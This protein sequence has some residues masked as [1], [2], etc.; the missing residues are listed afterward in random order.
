VQAGTVSVCIPTYRRNERLRALLEDLRLQQRPPEQIVV[1]D[2]DASGSARPVIEEVRRSGIGCALDY[3]IQ[4]EPNIAL[5]RNRTVALATGEWLAFVDDDERAPKEWLSRLLEAAQRYGADG[6]L[7]P[8]EPQVPESAPRW[9]RRGRFYDFPHQRSGDPVPLPCMRFGNVLLRADPVRALRGPFDP[10]FGLGGGED[11]DLL[12][13]LVHG[14]A[15][16]VWSE[17][18]PVFEPIE[19]KRLNLGWLLRRALGGGQDFALAVVRGRYRPIGWAGRVLFYGQVTAQMLI[20]GGLACVS[21]PLGRHRAAAWLIK[22]SA[23]FG[24]LSVL[25][26]SKYAGYSRSPGAQQVDP[27]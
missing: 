19:P 22:A 20:A 6:V 27:A 10:A 23:N 11:G 13:R 3:D 2:N 1:V 15:R 12:V 7:A 26:G 17:E 14:G 5:T 8:V 9:I 25:W 21:L 24:K 16:V 4:P 18:A